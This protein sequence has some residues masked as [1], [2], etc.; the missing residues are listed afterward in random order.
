MLK[1]IIK[2]IRW[3]LYDPDDPENID[4]Q[5]RKLY[6]EDFVWFRGRGERCRR[7]EDGVLLTIS[8]RVS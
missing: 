5:A 3:I 6:V 4:S 1:Y 7:M 2:I 8:M